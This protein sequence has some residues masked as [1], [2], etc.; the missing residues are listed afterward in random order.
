MLPPLFS[1]YKPYSAHIITC[2]SPFLSITLTVYILSYP[3]PHHFVSI[4]HVS[5][6]YIFLI[7]M[8]S[9]FLHITICFYFSLPT[10]YRIKT[11]LHLRYNT[12]KLYI[13]LTHYR[14][15]TPNCIHSI[16][17]PHSPTTLPLFIHLF[18]LFFLTW[19]FIFRYIFL[20]FHNPLTF[21]FDLRVLMTSFERER[22]RER[23][24][25]GERE[26]KRE[27]RR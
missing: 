7:I 20:P 3:Y 15:S 24:R 17:Y 27:P 12:T 4:L 1:I 8:N 14:I 22:E 9:N 11:D 5:T 21:M 19:T 18:L 10:F 16:T 13:S 2:P 25:E 6:L 26:R 23:E